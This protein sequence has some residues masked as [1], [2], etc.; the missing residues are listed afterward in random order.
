MA[1]TVEL[2]L[3]FLDYDLIRFALSIPEKYKLNKE[4]NKII[5]REVAQRIGVP[6]SFASRKKIAA[7]YGSNFDKALEKLAKKNGWTSK[8]EYLQKL[9]SSKKL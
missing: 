2:R 4:Q 6:S 1:H 8:K 3:P 7:Q 9:N 5:L